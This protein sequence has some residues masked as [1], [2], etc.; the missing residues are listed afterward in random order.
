M[1]HK[2]TSPSFLLYR[3]IVTIVFRIEDLKEKFGTFGEVGDVYIPRNIRN[4][5]PRGYAFVRFLDKRDAEDAQRGLDNSELD[6]RPIT[7]QEAKQKRPDLIAGSRDS[8]RFDRGRDN[9]YE[10]RDR[11]RERDRP[12]F[13]DRDRDYRGRGRSRSFSRSRSPRRDRDYSGARSH[14]DRDR[15]PP[16]RRSRTPDR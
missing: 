16:R 10:R 2:T 5:E 9:N 6:G 14:R 11:D 8:A 7:I 13:R 1:F 12:S 3:I 4:N 15:S